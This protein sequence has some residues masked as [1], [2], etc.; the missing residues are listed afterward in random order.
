M[1]ILITGGT[2]FL[3]RHVAK[4]LSSEGHEIT[5]MGRND[6]IGRALAEWN[7]GYVKADLIEK[8]KVETVCVGK[9]AVIHCG[10]LA[11]PWGKYRIFY[12]A[13][14]VGTQHVVGGCL[15]HNV[16][17]LV[18]ISTPSLYF[19]YRHRLQIKESDPL[20]RPRTH[21]AA[22][23]L[24]A[25]RVI[26]AAAEKGLEVIGI[27]P[28]AIFGPGDQAVLVRMIRVA[29]SGTVPLVGG[30]KSYVDISYIDNVVDAVI[31]CL[32]APKSALNRNYNVTNGE[33][34]TVET[35]MRKKLFPRL[36]LHPKYRRVPFSFA[37][38]AAAGLESWYRLR[39]ATA[40][41]AIT[42][43]SVGLMAKSQ[44][45]DISAA[46]R[47]LGYRPRVS[48]DEGMDRFASW[49][50][51]KRGDVSVARELGLN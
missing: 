37:Y 27:R 19:D 46:A 49:W 38:L 12:D 44:T 36:G 14:V 13:N 15:R 35:L 51:D 11:S 3:G 22:T 40:E 16:R 28:R 30:G 39:G 2:G 6:R 7:I 5:V 42:R 32:F 48:I 43:Y 8:E 50:K 25:D 45:L 4:R 41:P 47:E 24:L 34:I 31:L 21:Y 20:P 18:H 17:R 1:R 10:G 26:E 23:K 33:P 9:D 29:E